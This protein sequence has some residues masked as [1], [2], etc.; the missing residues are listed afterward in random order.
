M[1]LSHHTHD[2]MI[3]SD[4]LPPPISACGQDR[5]TKKLMNRLVRT[6]RRQSFSARIGI[7]LSDILCCAFS[8][9][10]VEMVIWSCG[11]ACQLVHRFLIR[12]TPS[13]VWYQQPNQHRRWMGVAAYLHVTPK[14]ALQEER[15]ESL[16]SLRRLCTALRISPLRYRPAPHFGCS[17]LWPLCQAE[18]T[19]GITKP[20]QRRFHSS[21]RKE[22]TPGDQHSQSYL[23]TR[24]LPER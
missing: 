20:I 11:A 23:D 7:V 19:I 3:S 17:S 13:P 9:F 22:P 6:S 14:I 1:Q 5:R 16:G 10:S 4:I 12:G 21:R 2:D 24:Q 18:R 8:E 15:E